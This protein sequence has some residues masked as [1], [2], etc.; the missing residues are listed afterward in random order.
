MIDKRTKRPIKFKLGSYDEKLRKAKTKAAEAHYQEGLRLSKLEGIDIQKEAAKEFAAAE[1]YAPGY[2]DAG[3]LYQTTRQ[4]G[5]KRMAIIPFEDRSGKKEAYG[6]VSENIA[7]E[8]I[9]EIMNDPSAIEFLE[10]ITRDQL[11]RIMQEQSLGLTGVIDDRTAVQ[12][13]KVL[14]CMK[15]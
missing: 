6:G 9:S 14:A 4:A 10:I 7:D 5:I 8:A 3:S 2:K 1:R 15:S 11:E 13:G 12:L